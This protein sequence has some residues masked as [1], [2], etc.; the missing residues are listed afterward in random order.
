[1][2]V[3]I[4]WG[5]T[6]GYRDKKYKNIF[7]I[8]RNNNHN[9]VNSNLY[10]VILRSFYS[11]HRALYLPYPLNLT[12][13]LQTSLAPENGTPENRPNNHNNVNSNLYIII[14]R[15]FYP[16]YKALYPPCPL[17][18]AAALRTSLAPENGAPENRS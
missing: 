15:S 12:A 7:S 1:V 2:G 3:C 18:L 14:L 5:T 8:I 9:S 6:L 13:A 17:N 4:K 16:H 11:P 10:I